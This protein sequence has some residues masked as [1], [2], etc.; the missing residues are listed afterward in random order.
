[1]AI[2]T[3]TREE[4]A[5]MREGGRR[6]AA[7]LR[8]LTD[9]ARAGVSTKELDA[10]AER[11]IGEHGGDPVFKGYRI[12]GVRTPYP[13][14]ICTSI[15]D[16]VVHGIPRSDR[17][18]ADGDIIGID[19]GM[20]W[21]AGTAISNQQLAISNTSGP[22]TPSRKPKV[23]L[24]T[25]MAVTIGI[26]K[27]SAEAERLIRATREALDIAVATI[28]PGIRIGDVSHAIETRLK[29]DKLVVIR[30]LAGHGVGH[31]LHEEPMIPNF[32]KPGTGVELLEGMVIAVEPMATLGGWR[33]TLDD[34]EW[35]FRTADGSLAAHFEHTIAVTPNGCEVLT[36]KST[37]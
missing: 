33:I 36:K 13:A 29:R 14:S 17:I 4:I 6:L 26:G 28:R 37:E 31:E 7:I 3:K 10:E 30:D 16:E 27:I 19:I 11:M 9:M 21:P 25:D 15:N 22:E 23:G 34:D 1:M 24:V 2:R 8:Y 20:R 32:G 12:E 5:L 18:L 35:T